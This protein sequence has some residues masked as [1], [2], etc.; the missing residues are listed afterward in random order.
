MSLANQSPEPMT[1]IGRLLVDKD[2]QAHRER[3]NRTLEDE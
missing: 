3:L 1:D 2:S